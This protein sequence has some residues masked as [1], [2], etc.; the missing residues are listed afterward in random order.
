MIEHPTPLN[1]MRVQ[2]PWQGSLRQ[3]KI[4][5]QKS[6]LKS[7]ARLPREPSLPSRRHR[8]MRFFLGFGPG[9]G[10]VSLRLAK[11][12]RFGASPST[13][14]NSFTDTFSF[15]A[16]VKSV[17]RVG[18]PVPRSRPDRSRKVN[19]DAARSTC[20][21]PDAQRAC[22]TFT[23]TRFEK[24]SKSTSAADSM[25]AFYWMPLKGCFFVAVRPV[26]VDISCQIVNP[27]RSESAHEPFTLTKAAIRGSARGCAAFRSC[28]RRVQLLNQSERRPVP[29]RRS[30]R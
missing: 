2:D 22:R 18:L 25:T 15:R 26:P 29:I 6:G 8:A 30:G 14:T 11:G 3:P 12:S 10:G 17:R 20:V 9:F 4:S 5:S 1:G 7:G 24:R 13:S 21:M 19:A 23:P 27:P 16:S 28:G